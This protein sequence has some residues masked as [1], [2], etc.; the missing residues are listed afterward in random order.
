VVLAGELALRR[1]L[2]LRGLAHLDAAFRHGADVND[3][4]THFHRLRHPE[5][6]RQGA[7]YPLI[8]D[9]PALLRI[10]ACLVEDQADLGFRQTPGTVELV[11]GDPAEDG[12]LTRRAEPLGPIV[13]HR[14]AAAYV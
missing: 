9:L 5:Q 6:P 7:D 14:Q 1:N 11:V 3:G 12:A 2:Q 13:S 10:K 4:V 8:A